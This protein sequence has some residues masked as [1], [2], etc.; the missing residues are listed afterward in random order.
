LPLH[1]L[2]DV[3]LIP[4]EGAAAGGQ[5]VHSLLLAAAS[6][7]LAALL[8]GAGGHPL[9][10]LLPDVPLAALA[11]TCRLLYGSAV[12]VGR[13]QLDLISQLGRHT[14]TVYSCTGAAVPNPFET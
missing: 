13:E 10:L 3:T 5:Q 12:M 7:H 8:E 9:Q 6:P 4:A 2:T 1:G 14:T 11:P